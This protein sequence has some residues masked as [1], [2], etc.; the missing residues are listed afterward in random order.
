MARKLYA[1]PNK[2]TK[3]EITPL[4]TDLVKDKHIHVETLFFNNYS[5][6]IPG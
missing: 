4:V 2:R 6:H 5:L 1:E 3:P